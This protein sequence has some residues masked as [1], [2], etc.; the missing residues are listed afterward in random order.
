LNLYGP[1]L[2]AGVHVE[3]ISPDYREVDV[4][5]RMRPWNRN[6]VGTHFGGS[7]YSMVDPF[8]MLML[9][10]L[11]GRDYIVWDQSAQIDFVSPGQGVVR[12]AFRLSQ[13]Q[14]DAMRAE[15]ADGRA[16][17]PE[18]LVEVLGEDGKVVAR[19]RKTLYVRLKPALRP[20]QAAATNAGAAGEAS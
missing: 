15:A 4:V 17:R 1:Y 2:G 12:A 18:L 19:V 20:S 16:V 11:L 13:T 5:M 8:Y 6:A 7:L 14:V 9:M 3:R 10:Q